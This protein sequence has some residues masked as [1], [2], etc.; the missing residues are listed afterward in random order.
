MFAGA[1]RL[2]RVTVETIMQLS[3]GS[4]PAPPLWQVP[5]FAD[6]LGECL[7]ARLRPGAEGRRT[8]D[9]TAGGRSSS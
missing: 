8:A 9:V 5:L 2:G 7:P 3:G 4:G 6:G 1:R